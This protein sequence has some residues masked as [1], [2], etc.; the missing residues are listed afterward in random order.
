MK[1]I[2]DEVC[3]T[4]RSNTTEQ[5]G[6]RTTGSPPP[7]ELDKPE[8]RSTRYDVHWGGQGRVEREVE[9]EG[10]WSENWE[11]GKPGNGGELASYG[12]R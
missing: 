2:R 10:R 5:R 7:W 6:V 9:K 3:T 4:R 8:A 11:T 1:Q 12:H